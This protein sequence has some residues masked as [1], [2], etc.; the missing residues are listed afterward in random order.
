MWLA[1]C[2]AERRSRGGSGRRRGGD[3]GRTG[4]LGRV[5]ELDRP[6]EGPC[7]GL[8]PGL[9]HVNGGRLP[10]VGF[11][12]ARFEELRREAGLSQRGLGLRRP[13]LTLP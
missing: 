6:G 7:G 2:E 13:P 9:L 5:G 10:R 4:R 3:S 8:S 11:R 1:G 12:P